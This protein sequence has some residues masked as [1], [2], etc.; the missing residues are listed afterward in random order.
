MLLG[1]S[2]GHDAT[3]WDGPALQ[4]PHKP[5]KPALALGRFLHIRQR[6]RHPPIGFFDGLVHRFTRL[7]FQT[8]F[9][10]PDIQRGGLEA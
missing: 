10:V 1:A 5:L 8:V 4:C 7:G 6:P 3:R 9:G 2:I